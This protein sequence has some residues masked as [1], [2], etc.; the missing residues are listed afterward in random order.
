M[1][2]RLLVK[3]ILLPLVALSG[4]ASA[5]AAYEAC[6]TNTGKLAVTYRMFGWPDEFHSDPSSKS[7][8]VRA[9][10]LLA[11]VAYGMRKAD[12]DKKWQGF[13]GWS[14]VMAL[15]A[16]QSRMPPDEFRSVAFLKCVEKYG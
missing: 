3:L 14:A 1:T 12:M 5:D 16:A 6:K 7:D 9:A 2:S 11:G 4:N 13:Y 8:P 15:S 10:E